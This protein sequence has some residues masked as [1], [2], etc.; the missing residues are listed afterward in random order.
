[1]SSFSW[2]I[3]EL[4]NTEWLA[5]AAIF[6]VN[7]ILFSFARPLVNFVD[8]GKENDSDARIKI[9]RAL[10]LLVMVLQAINILMLGASSDYEN[11]FINA[12]LTLMAIYAGLLTYSISSYFLRKKFGTEKEF[13]DSI[14]FIET[15]SSR[16]VD[17]ML[18]VLIVIATIYFMILIWGA[19]SLL[20]TT[21][22]FGIIA[23]FLALSLIHL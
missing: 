23:A 11:Y 9:L 13:D 15:Y 3:P 20:E 21:G 1:M 4:S 6:A 10:N 7:I 17:L 22:I 8:S 2:L 5:H 19:N 12:G 16:L 14:V 18:L